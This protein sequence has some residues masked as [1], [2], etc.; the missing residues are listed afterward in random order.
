M[1][2]NFKRTLNWIYFNKILISGLEIYV[3][4]KKKKIG[5]EKI[6]DFSWYF[7]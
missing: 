6:Y 2:F 7:R 3:I 1:I 4:K 5:N